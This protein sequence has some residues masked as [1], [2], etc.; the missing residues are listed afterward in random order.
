MK[1]LAKISSFEEDCFDRKKVADYITK[2]IENKDEIFNPQEGLVIAID[3]P[4]G[5][6]KTTFLD[7]WGK[8]LRE[9]K[10]TIIRY[11]SWED[12]DYDTPIIPIS[13]KLS[14]M[15]DKS[16]EIKA[17]FFTGIKIISS[18]IA[19]NVIDK[20]FGE[21]TF[22]AVGNLLKK[23]DIALS[24]EK[25][26]N[27]G[28]TNDYIDDYEMYGKVKSK[29]KEL[30]ET[31]T[32]NKKVIFLI[33]ELDR[34]RPLYAISLLE[35]IKHYF[36]IPNIIFV[37]ALDMDQLKHSIATIYGQDMDSY[38]YI[39]R[40]FNHCIKL[41]T[42]DIKKYL[43]HISKDGLI[44]SPQF[45]N[46]LSTLFSD[47]NITLRDV[48]VIYSNILIF[49]I[50]KLESDSYDK[51]IFYSFFITLKYKRPELY[52]IIIKERFGY[53]DDKILYEKINKEYNIIFNTEQFRIIII[54]FSSGGNQKSIEEYLSDM[55]RYLESHILIDSLDIG[56]DKTLM[57]YVQTA[58]EGIEDISI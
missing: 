22:D 28:T 6:G 33:D 10:Y 5:T 49:R 4:W 2:I 15:F 58:M 36:N 45:F 41:P 52:E 26:S 3:S 51:L 54:M 46:K 53:R 16:E 20:K 35:T 24:L 57:S 43:N 44:K 9:E 56:K 19:K 30:L 17:K 13:V 34:C 27:L 12:D 7:L 32:K 18:K 14:K 25:M 39:R 31:Q 29:I 38:G 50:L 47:L 37:F 55:N 40:F 11:N 8:Q 21:E 1:V 42:P 23:D 48:D